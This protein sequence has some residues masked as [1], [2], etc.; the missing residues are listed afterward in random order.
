MSEPVVLAVDG[1]NT[2]TLAVVASLDG[3]V[4]ATGRSGCG[5]I[6]GAASATAAL[7][8]IEAAVTQ[9]TP[10]V[11]PAEIRAA[12][13]SLA[14]AD[15]PEDYRFYHDNLVARLGLS[16]ERVA[17]FNDGMGPLRLGSASGVGL[18]VVLGTG[19]AIGGRGTDGQTWHG[20]FWI[21]RHGSGDLG[22]AALRAVYRSELGLGPATG[23]VSPILALYGA[24][25]VEDL[26]HRFTR[27]EHNLEGLGDRA[28]TVLL[29]QAAAGDA[30]AVSVLRN[31]TEAIAGSAFAVARRVGLGPEAFPLVLAGGLLQS[32]LPALEGFLTEALL[33]R[34]PRARPV[35][36]ALPPV[37]GVVLEALSAAGASLDDR[38]AANLTESLPPSSSV[39]ADTLAS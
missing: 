23:L 13:F 12:T 28:A 29:E 6:Y 22:D 30:T 24:S 37:A 27:R 14:G 26:L 15:W 35:L 25:S 5:D 10:S 7:D 39:P 16:P 1:G 4:R 32:S 33:A 11:A 9:A 8:A 17:I 36:P 18:A 2:K 3:L 31:Y 20:S 21:E 34:L 38:L 19:T